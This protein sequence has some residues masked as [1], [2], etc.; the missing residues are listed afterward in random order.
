MSG[1]GFNPLQMQ[2]F[3]EIIGSLV[4]GK[5]VSKDVYLHAAHPSAQYLV[6]RLSGA[7]SYSCEANV[8]RVSFDEA[9]PTISFSFYNS[10]FD[11]PFPFLVWSHHFDLS[12]GR[13]RLRNEG[14]NPAILH[15]KELLLWPEHPRLQEYEYLTKQLIKARLLPA[16]TFIGRRD[17]WSSYLL[18]KGF[19]IKGGRLTSLERND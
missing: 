13:D 6:V 10:F 8:V 9:R 4:G 15:R 7:I 1:V 18:Q 12:S 16:S 14:K 17:H 5:R 19:A 2:N 11:D 3:R